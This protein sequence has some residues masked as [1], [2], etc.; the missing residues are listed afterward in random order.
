MVDSAGIWYC[1]FS[2]AFSN[3]ISYGFSGAGID[4]GGYHLLSFSF[5]FF[6]FVVFAFP[7]SCLCLCSVY[8][9]AWNIPGARRASCA[10]VRLVTALA[11]SFLYHF[12]VLVLDI[13]SAWTGLEVDGIGYIY[14][15]G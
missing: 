5:L 1:C 15:S 2:F 11:C 6:S 9:M 14:I 12:G 3:L 13:C 10:L 4:T 7:F 8:L